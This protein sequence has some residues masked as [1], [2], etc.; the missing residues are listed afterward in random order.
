MAKPLP[1]AKTTKFFIQTFIYW[2]HL[3]TSWLNLYLLPKPLNFL[4]APL[5]IGNAF[6]LHGQTSTS[7]QNH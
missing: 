1:L 7:Y 4:V 2:Q 3:S 6:L 5:Y